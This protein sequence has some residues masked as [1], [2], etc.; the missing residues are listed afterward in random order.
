MTVYKRD[1]GLY[2]VQALICLTGKHMSLLTDLMVCFESEVR[3]REF[4]LN[5]AGER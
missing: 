4:S 5:K 2:S 3:W 1:F